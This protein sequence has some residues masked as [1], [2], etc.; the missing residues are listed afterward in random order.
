MVK[1]TVVKL[2]AQHLVD[3]QIGGEDF[4]NLIDSGDQDRFVK[5]KELENKCKELE[6]NKNETTIYKERN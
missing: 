6:I 2:L 1:S 5:L 4:H 3:E